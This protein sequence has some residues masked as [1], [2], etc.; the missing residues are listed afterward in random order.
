M[1]HSFEDKIAVI[2]GGSSGIGLATAQKFIE[3]GAFVYIAARRKAE[4][5]KALKQLGS[6]A[7][8]VQ[9]DVSSQ[10]DLDKSRTVFSIMLLIFGTSNPAGSMRATQ[11]CE[12]L[13]KTSSTWE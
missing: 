7:R 13:T 4:L 10:A 1:S 9:A 6:S 3:E 2:T 12:T 11:F 5:D 8:A